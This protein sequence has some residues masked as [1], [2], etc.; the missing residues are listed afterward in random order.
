MGAGR[1]LEHTPS[2]AVFAV[3][4]F[5]LILSFLIE[6][7]FHKL[8]HHFEHKRLHSLSSALRK[9]KEELMVMGFC[10][11][12]LIV[13]EENI[14]SVCVDMRQV[15]GIPT[16][17]Q[18]QCPCAYMYFRDFVEEPFHRARALEESSVASSGINGNDG[19]SSS[20]SSSS[21]ISTSTST[22]IS[23]SN[24]RRTGSTTTSSSGSSSG[25]SSSSSSSS[26]TTSSSSSS[27]REARSSIFD[28]VAGP[29]RGCEY[30]EGFC[31]PD[32]SVLMCCSKYENFR[33]KMGSKEML[34]SECETTYKI[35]AGATNTSQHISGHRL[36]WE[37]PARRT[38]AAGKSESCPAGQETFIEQAALHQTHTVIFYIAMVHITLGVFSMWFASKKIKRWSEWE[39][40]GDDDNED[41]AHLDIPPP[42]G[43]GIAGLKRII[44]SCK[45]QFTQSVCPAS[46]IAI[47]RFYISKNKALHDK[48]PGR[49]QFNK[50]ITSHINVVSS[51]IL[52][53][54]PW[55]WLTLGLQIIL[56]GYGF[57][58][59]NIFTQISLVCILIS[60]AKLQMVSDHLTRKVYEEY[61]CIDKM[62]YGKNI[63]KEK[64]LGHMQT[65]TEYQLFDHY[66]P[67]FWMN[68]P[69]IIETM[70]KFCIWQISVSFTLFGYFSLKFE[71]ASSF[72]T[73]KFFSILEYV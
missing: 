26:S 8:E 7:L 10:S 15:R 47:R 65:S 41:P 39:H 16:Q 53:I 21:S 34:A 66:E 14:L 46:Y 55:M 71:A 2:L 62:V 43:T 17:M 73:C 3:F 37:T 40:Y 56:E 5:F 58:T 12:V 69:K 22:S 19:S 70:I 35:E 61:K 64:E 31:G 68:N 20:S 32:W 1:N 67:E 36:L 51:N 30:K 50:E 25:S 24:R 33:I 28:T 13:F 63:V 72:H 29:V 49:F 45:E 11:L 59:F 57:G 6:T 18:D 42:R 38:L 54:S 9:V 4:I 27:G 48:P 23:S 52:G 60:G 44:C